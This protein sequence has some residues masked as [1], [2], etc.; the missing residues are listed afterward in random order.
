MRTFEKVYERS[1][2]VGESIVFGG[3]ELVFINVVDFDEAYV[4]AVSKISIYLL[5]IES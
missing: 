3:E 4:K 2:F 5:N 1:S